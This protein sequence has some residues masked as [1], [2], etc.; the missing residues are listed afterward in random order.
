[1]QTWPPREQTTNCSGHS[2][3]WEESVLAFPTG[4]QGTPASPPEVPA[5]SADAAT[6]PR[7]TSNARSTRRRLP[8]R[9]TRC[10]RRVCFRQLV[11]FRSRSQRGF[12]PGRRKVCGCTSLQGCVTSCDAGGLIVVS[13]HKM[14]S[15]FLNACTGLGRVYISFQHSSLQSLQGGLS[16]PVR[17]AQLC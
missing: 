1:M 11:R 12:C 5:S 8:R 16:F 17:P 13:L 14:S 9:H 15:S 2:L 3:P 10:H 6:A 7:T 4:P